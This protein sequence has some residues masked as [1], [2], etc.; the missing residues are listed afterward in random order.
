MA[1]YYDEIHNIDLRKNHYSFEEIGGSVRDY[2]E[3]FDIDDAYIIMA[4]SSSMNSKYMLEYLMK[5]LD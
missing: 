3:Y 4:T 2:I 1:A 5:Y